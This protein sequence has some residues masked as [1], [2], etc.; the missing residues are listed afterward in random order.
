LR[1]YKWQEIYDSN[2]NQL[3]LPVYDYLLEEQR[4]NFNKKEDFEE[5]KGKRVIIIDM[6]S[7]DTDLCQIDLQ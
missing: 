4:Q 3:F 7:P 6:V 5:K 2:D 1:R